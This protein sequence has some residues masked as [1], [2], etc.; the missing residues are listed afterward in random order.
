MSSSFTENLVDVQQSSP[1]IVYEGVWSERRP[2]RATVSSDTEGA[3]MEWDD[4]SPGRVH[5][6]YFGTRVFVYAYRPV[7]DFGNPSARVIYDVWLDKQQVASNRTLPKAEGRDVVEVFDSGPLPIGEHILEVEPKERFVVEFSLDYIQYMSA[8]ITGTDLEASRPSEMA[9]GSTT[10]RPTQL[11]N[12]DQGESATGKAP[13]GAIVGGVLGGLLCIASLLLALY[14]LRKRRQKKD[15][16][17]A[18]SSG[19]APIV[20]VFYSPIEPTFKQASMQKASQ[21]ARPVGGH[22]AN[23]PV[24]IPAEKGG[25]LS[26]ADG[27]EST[28]TSPQRSGSTSLR[29]QEVLATDP[30]PYE[31]L[32]PRRSRY[33]W[34]RNST[35]SREYFATQF[36]YNSPNRISGVCVAAPNFKL[37]L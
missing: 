31:K 4:A 27:P 36:D 6:S 7:G 37:Q 26:W 10:N 3:V 19:D 30:P 25:V 35:S 14:L 13:V 9:S 21:S 16:K 15:Q 1:L 5:F 24:L 28:S 11:P 2:A 17:T 12:G 33:R 20:L 29:G 34:S 18:T 23:R 22:V 8:T 32:S